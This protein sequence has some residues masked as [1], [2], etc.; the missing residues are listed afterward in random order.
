MPITKDN[1]TAIMV[2]KEVKE[3]VTKLK[4]EIKDKYGL[5]TNYSSTINYLIRFF[6]ENK[7]KK[8]ETL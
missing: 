5:D 1:A 2:E 8:T 7:D 6:E 4:R 3:K